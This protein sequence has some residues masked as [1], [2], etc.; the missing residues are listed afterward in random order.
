MEIRK[1]VISNP[2]GLHG[3][4]A[5][6]FVKEAKQFN[7]KIKIRNISTDGD[8]VNAKSVVMLLSAGISQNTEVEITAEG[9]DEKNAVEHM[10]ELIESGFGEFEATIRTGEEL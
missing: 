10:I 9:E 4:P 8:F 7:S 6:S 2:T 5:A 3:R 1:A